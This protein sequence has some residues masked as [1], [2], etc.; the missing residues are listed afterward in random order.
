MPL[1]SIVI[2]N[3]NGARVLERCLAALER[4]S[5]R[6]FEIILIDN[7]STDGSE[8]GIEDRF[9]GVRLVGLREN[10]GFA[11]ANNLG[12]RLARGRWL[13]L[14]N[15]DA[16]ARPDWL[17]KLMAAAAEHPRFSFFASCL[18]SAQ[19]P[20]T[21]DGVGDV[22]HISGLAWR[23]GYS[24]P[25]A[26]FQSGP[27]EV[28]GACGAAALY[29]REQFLEAGGFDESFFCYHEDVDLSFR[30]RLLGH[31]CLYVPAAVVEHVGSFSYGPKNDFVV[32]H[33]HRNLVWTFFKNMPL[34]LLFWYLPAHCLL[35]GITLLWF[36]KCGQG[37]VIV[38]AKKDAFRKFSEIRRQRQQIQAA[39]RASAAEISQAMEHGLRK[40][41]RQ[42]IASH[43]T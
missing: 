4:Q 8:A 29:D 3:W 40:S 11:S 27:Q 37:R 22:Y 17:E 21:V 23:R 38:K 28:F 2:V 32:Y 20:E 7:G 35:N 31:R 16:F 24:L 19:A 26:R 30:L 12:A 1:I 33:G 25:L 10:S 9:P 34:P 14:L 15:N 39:R 41:I 18:V 6:D 13:A 43:K 36:W 42:F 5:F